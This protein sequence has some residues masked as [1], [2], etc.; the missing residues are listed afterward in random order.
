MSEFFPHLTNNNSCPINPFLIQT[1]FRLQFF[2]FLNGSSKFEQAGAIERLE[3]T[4]H[5]PW[6][7]GDAAWCDEGRGF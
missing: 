4:L 1:K 3:I 2:F 5:F 6:F 7:F